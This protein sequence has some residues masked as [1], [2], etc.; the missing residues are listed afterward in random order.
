MAQY[1]QDNDEGTEF[2]KAT[3]V[4]VMTPKYLAEQH[5]CTVVYIKHVIKYGTPTLAGAGK[6]AEI[7]NMSTIDFLKLGE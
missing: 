6:L 5:N 7:F 2:C 4:K 3:G 1:A